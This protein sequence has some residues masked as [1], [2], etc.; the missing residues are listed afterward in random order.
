MLPNKGA[1]FL[2]V[3]AEYVVGNDVAVEHSECLEFADEGRDIIVE[4][5]HLWHDY[6]SVEDSFLFGEEQI[7]S[8][9][10][11]PASQGSGS[12]YNPTPP[13]ANRK[14][15]PVDFL[16]KK[17]AIDYW[18]SGKRGRKTWESV[19]KRFKHLKHS[20]QLYR[21]DEQV[22]EAGS[23]IDKLRIINSGVLER[24]VNY[25]DQR[26]IVH[27]FDLRRFALDVNINI[28][29][30]N[31]SASTLWLLNFKKTHRIVSR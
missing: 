3:I 8:E 5:D 2:D 1:L 20:Q 19:R 9:S 28:G 16:Y 14:Y 15:R 17:R 21:W 26:L 30:T 12:A 18:K 27:D 10:S 13:E 6:D 7:I 11:Q 24:F 25:R 4:C 23:R 29:L 31:F 22:H